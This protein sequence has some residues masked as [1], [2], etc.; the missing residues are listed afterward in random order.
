MEPDI[1][2]CPHCDGLLSIDGDGDIINAEHLVE[3]EPEDEKARGV[4]SVESDP[5]WKERQYF[6]TTPKRP[7][8]DM[9]MAVVGRPA[10]EPIVAPVEEDKPT[11]TKP[12]TAITDAVAKDLK[13]RN[14]H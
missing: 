12:D 8:Y 13:Q 5:T 14:I 4:Y 9:R 7:S 6:A 1:W 3:P 10:P 2:F 11:P